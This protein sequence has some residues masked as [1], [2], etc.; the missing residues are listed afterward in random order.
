MY[1]KLPLKFIGITDMY[2]MRKHP[3]TGVTT[4]HYGTDFGWNKYQGEPLYAAYDAKVVDEGYDSSLGN[5]IVLKYNID[6][7]TII[8]RYLHLKNKA[9][10]KKGSKVN[11][12]EII[13]YMGETGSATAVHLHFE[14]WIC[15]NIYSY[16]GSDY[17]KYAVDPLKHCYLFE[18][19]EAGSSSLKYLK[20]V[21][22]S[23]VKKD[24][25]RNQ[26]EVT[27]RYLNCRDKG[28]LEGKKLGYI[29]LGYYNILN[30][31]T[32]DGYIWYEIGKD[33]WIAYLK[34]AVTRHL[35]TNDSTLKPAENK[36]TNKEKESAEKEAD[37]KT[38][39]NS[40]NNSY[41]GENNKKDVLSSLNSFEAPNDDY[42][43]IYLKKGEVIYYP[44]QE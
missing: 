33:R 4:F 8:N 19:Q 42:Y 40:N 14:Y 11:Q 20:K 18:D 7:K 38:V 24:E 32:S 37:S 2:G 26:L 13:G 41:E 9:A 6:K 39:N 23:P 29:K 44:K 5:Y 35:V 16:K 28:S 21:V 30:T 27:A 17:A 31:K 43:Y 12:G 22:G 1:P 34:D 25:S 3:I 10:F 36:T 15:P